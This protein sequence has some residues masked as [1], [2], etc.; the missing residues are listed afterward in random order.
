MLTLAYR[1]LVGP[2]LIGAIPNRAQRTA[3]FDS[4]PGKEAKRM[5]SAVATV[6]RSIHVPATAASWAAPAT[7]IAT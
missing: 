7:R 4:R 1:R 5:E 2:Q 3:G 6:P